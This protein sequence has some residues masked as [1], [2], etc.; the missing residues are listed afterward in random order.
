MKAAL[1]QFIAFI[2][3]AAFVLPSVLLAAGPRKVRAAFAAF[4]YPNAPFWIAKELRV[5]EKYRLDVELVYVGGARPVR[6][7]LGGSVDISQ[8]GGASI[9]SAAAQR[10]EVIILRTCF[11]SADLWRPCRAAN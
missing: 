5:F 10:A 9:V 4:A 6:A 3:F 2:L 1:K 11:Y 7:M 8:A